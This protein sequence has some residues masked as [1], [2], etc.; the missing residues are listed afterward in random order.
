MQ[1]TVEGLY[2]HKYLVKV[3]TVERRL[4]FLKEMASKQIYISLVCQ[5]SGVAR[6]V[7]RREVWQVYKDL[8]ALHWGVA[9]SS[10]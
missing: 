1:R 9:D 10:F 8:P 2:D 7:G 6:C 5:V 4:N 3:C